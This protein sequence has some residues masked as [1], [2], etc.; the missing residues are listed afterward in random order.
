MNFDPKKLK[1]KTIKEEINLMACL[2]YE[3]SISGEY[4]ECSIAING[5]VS[6]EDFINHHFE[7]M[8]LEIIACVENDFKVPKE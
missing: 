5:N 8:Y 1:L 4:V 2:I 3:G 6:A 7:P